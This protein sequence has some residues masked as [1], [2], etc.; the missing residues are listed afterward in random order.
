MTMIANHAMPT[1]PLKQ[2]KK[3]RSNMKKDVTV[4]DIKKMILKMDRNETEGSDSFNVALLL[5]SAAHI[6]AERSRLSSFTGLPKK[7]IYVVERRLRKNGVWVGERTSCNW[8]DKKT[9]TISF[10]LDVGI[11]LGHIERV[12]EGKGNVK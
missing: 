7:F 10:Y 6:G 11:G 4:D 9:G 5:L 3:R 2:R 8:K 12:D 1:G